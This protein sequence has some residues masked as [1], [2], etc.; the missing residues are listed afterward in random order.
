ML[1][2][3]IYLFLLARLAERFGTTDWGRLFVV[4]AGCFGT[5][6]TP[7]LITLNNH[8][9]ASCSVIVAVYAL[10]RILS[11]SRAHWGWFVVAGFFAGF[12]AVNELPAAAFALGLGLIL[13]AR[14]P[15]P[16]LLAFA[17]AVL[18]PVAAL[19]VLNYSELGEISLGYSKFGG[20]WYEYEGSHW[21]NL[22]D[23]S[24]RGIDWA[25]NKEG[26]G[27]YAFNVLLGHHGWFS[28]TPI[29]LLTLLGMALGVRY[30]LPMASGVASAP[31]ETDLGG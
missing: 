29:Y 17:P 15:K 12:T 19:L 1:P 16:T 18:V 14:F 7:F 25:K 22:P 23:Q 24:K 8:T 21:R 10:V 30:L 5:L 11:A 2:F 20:P 3:V 13:L 26:K 9:V 28:L 27:A 31:R 4:A 6:V